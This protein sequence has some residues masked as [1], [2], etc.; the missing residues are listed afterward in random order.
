MENNSTNGMI[1]NKGKHFSSREKRK[2]NKQNN[3]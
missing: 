2:Y 1:D 3:T